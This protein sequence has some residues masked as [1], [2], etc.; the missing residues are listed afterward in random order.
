LPSSGAGNFTAEPAFVDSARDL[1]LQSNSPCINAGL[2][3]YATASTDFDSR[4]RIINGTVDVGAFE[5]QGSGSSISYAWLQSYGLPTDGSADYADTDSDRLNNWQEWVSGTDPTNA[6]SALK[7][8]SIERSRND[9]TLTWQS[10]PGIN[11]LVQ[12]ASTLG[13]N[14][15]FETIATNLFSQSGTN[16]TFIDRNAA[17]DSIFFYRIGVTAHSAVSHQFSSPQ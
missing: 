10:A 1:H 14:S 4:P 7:L 2:N 6:V 9:V 5:Y 11:Y 8:T 3:A 12:R 16:T 13:S 17:N 15:E